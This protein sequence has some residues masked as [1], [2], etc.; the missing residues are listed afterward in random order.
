MLYYIHL[1]S[2]WGSYLNYL[3]LLSFVMPWWHAADVKFGVYPMITLTT[4]F[5]ISFNWYVF[6]K[7]NCSS[8]INGLLES[9]FSEQK[10]IILLC[11]DSYSIYT[12]LYS[13]NQGARLQNLLH[14]TW[15]SIDWNKLHKWHYLSDYSFLQLFNKFKFAILKTHTTFFA[16]YMLSSNC[17]QKQL[18]DEL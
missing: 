11:E 2:F 15:H 3:T 17:L 9:V 12:A 10:G 8:F 6:T 13:L 14:G 1:W 5:N 16:L 7:E 4:V 18:Q